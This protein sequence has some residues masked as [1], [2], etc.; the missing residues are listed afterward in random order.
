[1]AAQEQHRLNSLINSLYSSVAKQIQSRSAADFG[2]IADGCVHSCVDMEARLEALLPAGSM[3]VGQ[4]VKTCLLNTSG[5]AAQ[6][7]VELTERVEC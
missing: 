1:V 7:T 4:H 5:V 3:Y 2:L 6:H